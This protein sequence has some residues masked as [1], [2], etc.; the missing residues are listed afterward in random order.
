[1]VSGEG[2]GD[3]AAVVL[4]DVGSV[5]VRGDGSSA[6]V[7]DMIA[8][9]LSSSSASVDE[10]DSNVQSSIVVEAYVDATAQADDES[11][12][13]IQLIELRYVHLQADL[14]ATA[15][16]I[17]EGEP[18]EDVIQ[19]KFKVNVT[20]KILCCLKDGEDLNDEVINFY[21]AMLNDYDRW[22]S[23]ENPGCKKSHFFSSFFIA[24]LLTNNK[25]EY[26]NV[27]RWTKDID[28][29]EFDNIC[30]P[31]NFDD[32]HWMLAVVYPKKKEI[33]FCDSIGSN[34]RLYLQRILEWVI[35]E[36]STKK[37]V[38]LQPSDW[39]LISHRNGIPQQQNKFDCGTFVI[40][41]AD[42]L[43]DD[44]PLNETTYNQERMPIWRQKIAV[45]I[46]RG[47]LTYYPD[48]NPIYIS[49]NDA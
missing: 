25:Y 34:G 43:S 30:F 48:A 36:A 46:L 24:K 41:C 7:G 31:I 38:T 37:G 21:M 12:R 19:N 2:K 9:N 40:A 8:E 33:H 13:N 16:A 29:F 23:K 20:K 10:V 45:D 27:S 22:K 1:V 4:E 6:A 49:D 44:L 28:I 39:K 17:L 18:T 42:A 26:R 14:L 32:K 11:V 15:T 35:D 47:K 5:E 3:V